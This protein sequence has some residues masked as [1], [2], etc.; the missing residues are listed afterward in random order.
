M[1]GT[2]TGGQTFRGA[3]GE[4]EVGDVISASGL[5]LQNTKFHLEVEL[6]ALVVVWCRCAVTCGDEKGPG[7]VEGPSGP[8][9]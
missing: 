3:G 4:E 9:L 1:C 7:G 2:I 6:C 8:D 5:R